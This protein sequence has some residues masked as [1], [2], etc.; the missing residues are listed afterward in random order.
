MPPV[1]ITS[2]SANA[3]PLA[4]TSWGEWVAFAV[5]TSAFWA[6]WKSFPPVWLDNRTHGFI[7]AGLTGW[8]LWQRRDDLGQVGP[9]TMPALPL[10]GG[11]SL[12]WLAGQI[13]SAQLLHQLSVPAVLWTW[14]LVTRGERSARAALPALLVFT[15]ALPV[16]ELLMWPLQLA[17]ATVAGLIARLAGVEATISQE[18][19]SLRWGKL[20]VAGSCS[21]LGFFMTAVT[22]SSVY[23]MLFARSAAIRWRIVLLAAGMAVLANWVRVAGLMLIA[24]AT[25][26]QSSLMHDHELFGWVIFAVAMT[27]SFATAGRMER[28]ERAD[29]PSSAIQGEV[30]TPRSSAP[31]SGS[32]P[33]WIVPAATI[34]AVSGPML[35][36]AVRL[37]SNDQTPPTALRGIAAPSPWTAID[38]RPDTRDRAT[39]GADAWTPAFQPA[40]FQQRS[41]WVSGSDTVRIDHF[42]YHE[43]RQ[44]AELVGGDNEVASD[45]VLI[46]DRLVGP[47]DGN[48][49]IVRQA[50]VR[51]G[52]RARLIWYWY[53]VA[54]I[55]TPSAPK[56]KLLTLLA[57]LQRREGGEVT[58]VS[59]PCAG[60]A[61]VSAFSRLFEFVTGHSAP[62]T[63]N[64][65][66]Q[67]ATRRG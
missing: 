61:C 55:E 59:T 27:I 31:P 12:L 10:I 1:S 11:L 57:F 47:L 8:L 17:A 32:R 54:G 63:P 19:I 20:V 15:L 52:G 40:P 18:V 4:T 6:T 58:F 62:A 41:L 16:W 22:L 48:L 45:S 21:G 51:E 36:W 46:E 49:R 66:P 64:T 43:E 3:R 9:A 28:S 53:R 30:S 34:L 35:L 7:A 37:S 60:G 42:A 2:P 24:D 67:A 14:L 23:A 65:A 29:L 38:P 39:V 26:M 50:I 13:M 44:G 56:A 33:G 25:R 5:V